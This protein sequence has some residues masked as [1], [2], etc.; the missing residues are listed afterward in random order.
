MYVRVTPRALQ[1]NAIKYLSST[2][3]VLKQTNMVIWSI[4]HDVYFN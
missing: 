4:G 3:K 1:R 2:D